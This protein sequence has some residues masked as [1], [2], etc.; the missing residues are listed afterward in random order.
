MVYIFKLCCLLCVAQIKLEVN[1]VTINEVLLLLV[2]NN[3]VE[4]LL[5]GSIIQCVNS[6]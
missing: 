1:V 3:A 6:F 4:R 5:R 2:M